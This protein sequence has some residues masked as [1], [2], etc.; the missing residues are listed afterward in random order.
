MDIT[1]S[2]LQSALESQKRELLS[3]LHA[4]MPGNVIS[5]DP[6]AG[7]AIIQPALRRKTSSGTVATAPVLS[8][9]PVLLPSSDFPVSPGAPCLLLFSD[10]CLDGWLETGQPVIPPSPRQHDLSDAI[11]LVGYCSAFPVGPVSD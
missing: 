2:F 10:F 3:V 11:A 6:T 4:V 8:D 5:Y 1:E 9:V 7:L